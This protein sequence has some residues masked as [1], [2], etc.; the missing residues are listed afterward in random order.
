MTYSVVI[1]EDES[2]VASLLAE[3]LQRG[4][5]FRVT[6][7]VG[8]LAGGRALLERYQPDLLLL[9]VYLPDGS[10]LDLLAELRAA[11]HGC[12][13][14]MITAA[15]EVASLERALQLGAFDFLVK[16]VL[17]QRLDRALNTFLQRQH[18]L[19]QA[20]SVTQ[21]VA[22]ALFSREGD[23]G[24]AVAPR[25]ARLPKGIDAL[26]L[27]RLREALAE[28]PRDFLSA[29][30]VGQRAGVSRSTARR[31]LEYL[32]QRHELEADHAYGSIGRPERRYRPVPG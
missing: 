9:D 2:E 10:G 24:E 15:S 30:E 4:N 22:D 31:Y 12:E 18:R 3:Y 11:G 21:S 1:V 29:Q 5:D 23:S 17:L 19:R 8:D 14:M 26:T 32:L 20:P 7:V 27:S 28:S 25:Q 6:A 13:V 16:P